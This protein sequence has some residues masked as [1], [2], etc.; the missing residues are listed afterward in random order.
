MDDHIPITLD[1]EANTDQALQNL[2]ELEQKAESFGN[3]L[4][5]AL[6]SSIV[7]GKDLDSVLKQL[8][9]SMS[10]Q[11]LNSALKPVESTMSNA[12]DGFLGTILPMGLG[13]NNQV[14]AFAK[15]GVVDS[16]TFFPMGGSTNGSAFGLMGEAGA[17][18]IL[19]LARGADGALGV[20]ASDGGGASATNITFHVTSP[21]AQ[22]FA[23]SETQISAM[24]ARAVGRGRRGL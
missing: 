16:P 5:Q 6:K 7:E 8:A 24:L 4:T 20:V 3:T 21:D 12:I 18:A 10:T 23:K 9:L 14:T 22:G 19:P 1:V 11:A 17:E 13:F 15:G 2:D